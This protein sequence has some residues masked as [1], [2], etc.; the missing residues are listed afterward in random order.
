M[1]DGE[2]KKETLELLMSNVGHPSKVCLDVL[3]VLLVF[4]V[5][6]CHDVSISDAVEKIPCRSQTG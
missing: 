4:L 6:V 3:T 5:A 2:K 1:I